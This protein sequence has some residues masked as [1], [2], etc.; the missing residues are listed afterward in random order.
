MD[1]LEKG[2]IRSIA[3]GDLSS[4]DHIY[5]KYRKDV[6]YAAYFVFY[7]EATA[8]D[9]MQETF[10]AFLEKAKKIKEDVNLG[11]YLVQMAK[12]KSYDLYMKRKKQ[13]H[14][15]EDLHGTEHKFPGHSDLLEKIEKILSEKEFMVFTLRVLGEY[16]FKEISKMK[17]IPVGS[18]TWIYQEARKKLE[19]EV[20]R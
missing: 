12:N 19:K 7:D 17:G 13:G 1:E 20:G 4:F 11:G 14:L 3:S 16:S 5:S 6:Y 15:E 9:I 18:L 10:V 2:Y 8:E